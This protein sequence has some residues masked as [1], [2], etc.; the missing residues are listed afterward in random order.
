MVGIILAVLG[1][2]VWTEITFKG[3]VSVVS[4]SMTLLLLISNIL[5]ESVSM[6][7]GLIPSLIFKVLTPSEAFSGFSNSGTITI[8]LLFIVAKGLSKSGILHYVLRYV[9]KNPRWMVTAQIRLLLPVSIIS[10]FTN[11]TPIVSMMIPVVQSW[12]LKIG[13][14]SSLLLMPLSFATILGGTCS[15]IGT[16][17]N[18]IVASLSEESGGPSIGFFDITLVGIPNLIIGLIYIVIF[19]R[20]L[21]PNKLNSSESYITNPK[22]YIASVIVDNNVLSGKSI[23]RA[24]LRNL[25]GVFLVEIWRKT[26]R[27]DGEIIIESLRDQ[28]FKDE[29][30]WSDEYYIITA[31]DPETILLAGDILYFSGALAH[32]KYIYTIDGLLPSEE[33]QILKVPNKRDHILVEAVISSHSKLI[34][35][36]PKELDFRKK[37][38][39]A[40]ISIYRVDFIRA[41]HIKSRIGDI[42]LESGDVL[43][44]ETNKHFIHNYEYDQ[45]F[46]LISEVSLDLDTVI[47]PKDILETLFMSLP[48]AIV[49]VLNIMNYLPLSV[50]S[51]IVTV[52][53]VLS[54]R[55]KYSTAL[56]ALNLNLLV[57]IAAGFGL[58]L[59]L[60][61][62]GAADVIAD[63]IFPI[64]TKAGILGILTSIYFITSLLSSFINNASAVTL[65]FPI[66]FK[67]ASQSEYSIMSMLITLMIAGSASFITPIGYQT[68]IMVQGPGNY[69]WLHFFKFGL[70]LFLTN[71]ITTILL[72]SF[73]Y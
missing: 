12:S 67:I 23:K 73:I 58:G 20:L 59:S 46:S 69:T 32:M 28:N 57:I 53:Y 34:G 25:P 71:A 7:I 41:R 40:I 15:I 10:A 61:I 35:Y 6:L 43:L 37:Y 68:N 27:S 19:S 66:V 49:I 1:I 38:D 31:P 44:I 14:N 21:L 48:Y 11:N 50:G 4:L 47:M 56:K 51:L 55:L 18:I 3:W 33:S 5:P 16:S 22:E 70:P 64:I 52:F 42:R 39:A 8:A 13:T 29:E 72:C 65:M 17:T 30:Y 2:T 45:N 36:T 63:S 62:S 26:D 54:S 60:D 24:G 9:L